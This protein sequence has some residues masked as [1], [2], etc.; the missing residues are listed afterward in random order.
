MLQRNEAENKDNQGY[1]CMLFIE[2]SL[3]KLEEFVWDKLLEA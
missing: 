3:S 1:R 2:L